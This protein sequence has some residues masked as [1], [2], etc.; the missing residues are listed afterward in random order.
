[1]DLGV[2]CRCGLEVQEIE[3]AALVGLGDVLLEQLAVAALVPGRVRRMPMGGIKPLLLN[4]TGRYT[5][6]ANWIAQ[7][8]IL[9]PG[10]IAVRI[11]GNMKNLSARLFRPITGRIYVIVIIRHSGHSV[12]DLMKRMRMAITLIGAVPENPFS[13]N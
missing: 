9:A 8:N 7:L 13:C 5:G 10:W 4:N 6:P 3:V 1:M 11:K 2:G 12:I